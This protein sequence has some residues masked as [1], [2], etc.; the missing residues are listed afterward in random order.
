[1]LPDQYTSTTNPQLLHNLLTSRSS[2]LIGS[3][4]FRNA[5]LSSLPL[6]LQL[7]PGV[8]V[9]SQSLYSGQA[10]FAKLPESPVTNASIPLSARSIAIAPNV[11]IA[12]SNNNNRLILW[13][14]VPDTSQLPS[15]GSL[16]LLDIQSSACSPPCS[17]PS[18]CSAD[19]T[20]TCPSGFSG[21]ACES[22]DDGYFGPTCE[23]CPEECA[24]CDQGLSGSGRCLTPPGDE[25]GISPS[26]CNCLH[27]TCEDDGKCTC[28]SGWAASQNGTACAS[29]APS[30]FLSTS[31]DC[32]GISQLFNINT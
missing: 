11:W 6:N 13:D 24:D 31:G 1:M 17:G 5:S 25:D 19:G 12:I 7:E 4:G 23:P 28:N 29:C 16:S 10:S 14:S 26:K 8:A 15:V 9:Y 27:G 3:A 21:S 20:C 18:V 32:Q 22:C 30:F 2:T